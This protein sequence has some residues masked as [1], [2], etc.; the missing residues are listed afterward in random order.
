MSN[1]RFEFDGLD[2]FK[3]WLRRLPVHLR[4][5]GAVLVEQ[6]G[7]EAFDAIHA[8]Y[9]AHKHSGNL[10]NHLVQ[11]VEVSKFGASVVIKNTAKHAVIFENGTQIRKNKGG[12]NRGA[13]P[14]GNI[15]I[16]V[17]QRKRR[18]MYDDLIELL[19]SADLEV[20][21]G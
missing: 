5:D 14:A 16:P 12:A 18:A 20:V 13:M 10:A 21:V 19:K 15:F 6:R 17:M 8:Q 11:E 2:E 9:T 4:D 3:A 1:N 7:D